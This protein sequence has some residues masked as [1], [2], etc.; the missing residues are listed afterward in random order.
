MRTLLRAGSDW[1][2]DGESDEH[3]R[4]PA[5]RLVLP[6]LPDTVI[7]LGWGMNGITYAHRCG[8]GPVGVEGVPVAHRH[9]EARGARPGVPLRL[10][11]GARGAGPVSVVGAGPQW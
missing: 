9:R 1:E 7:A 4:V 5:E 10:R 11:G 6:G 8:P 2:L 3:F